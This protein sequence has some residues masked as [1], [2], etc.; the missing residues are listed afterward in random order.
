MISHAK[1]NL[2]FFDA[3]QTIEDGRVK[4]VKNLSKVN[5]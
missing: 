1:A 3:V 5:M 2:E 4:S